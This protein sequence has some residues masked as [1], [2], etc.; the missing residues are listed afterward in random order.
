M[1]VMPMKKINAALLACS[2]QGGVMAAKLKQA[3]NWQDCPVYLPARYC[4]AAEAG[5]YSYESLAQLVR[6]LFAQYD[7]LV[8]FCA[9]GIAVRMIGPLLRSKYSDPAV[10]VCDE[11]G[12]FAI[13]LLSGHMGGANAFTAEI[14]DVLG[15]VPVITTA[16][17]VQGVF[18]VDSWAKTQQLYMEE[19]QLVKEISARLLQGESVGFS[20]DYCWQGTLPA[21]LKQNGDCQWG[22]CVSAETKQPFLHTLHLRPRNLVLGV[23]CRRG[24]TAAQLEQAFRQMLEQYPI[25]EK[26]IGAAATIDLKQ[27]EAGLLAWT[28]QKKLPIFF[29]TAE[30]LQHV[31][32]AFTPSA[33][34]QQITGV[35]NV[36]ERSAALASNGGQRIVAKQKLNGVTMAVYEKAVELS[37]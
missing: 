18:A 16:T 15:A 1:A 29:Y 3:E 24:I 31:S 19:K 10:V 9:C 23:G 37:F 20:S 13:S 17:D 4:Q 21:G 34:V 26:R 35:D 30:Q 8:F 25:E 32:G 14:A 6:Q 2:P 12:Q 5:V 11:G 36:C 27:Q 7:C 22:I 33:F 28:A